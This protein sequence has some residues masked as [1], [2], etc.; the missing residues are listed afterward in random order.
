MVVYNMPLKIPDELPAEDHDMIIKDLVDTAK[1][2]VATI[3]KIRKLN[4]AQ[5]K[6]SGL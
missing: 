1:N 2:R 3:V 4:V 6:R 5:K